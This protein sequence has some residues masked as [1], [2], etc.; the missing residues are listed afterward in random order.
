MRGPRTLHRGAPH[1]PGF[2]LVPAPLSFHQLSAGLSGRLL[3][4]FPLFFPHSQGTDLLG[5]GGTDLL[6]SSD[7]GGASGATTTTTTATCPGVTG[8]PVPSLGR[9]PPSVAHLEKRTRP[10]CTGLPLSRRQ[11]SRISARCAPVSIPLAMAGAGK[12]PPGGAAPFRPP[13]APPPPPHRPHSPL[14]LGSPP[15]RCP[16]G[17]QTPAPSPRSPSGAPRLAPHGQGKGRMKGATPAPPEEN[18]GWGRC[19]RPRGP[20]RPLGEGGLRQ[21]DRQC[22]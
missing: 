16:P 1:P 20:P 8:D 22:C 6:V 13:L 7:R 15:P 5:C 10:C 9:P 17:G 3:A 4:G 21:P 2:A 11:L 14:H 12:G 18:W 19:S